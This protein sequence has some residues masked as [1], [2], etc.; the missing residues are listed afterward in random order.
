MAV[1]TVK[2]L[3]PWIA[4]VVVLIG[5]VNFFWF[6]AE[7]SSLGGDALSGYV[8]DGHWF[9]MSH[10]TST[11]VSQAD[12]EWS[13]LHASSVF[14]THP[15]AMAG[16]AYLLFRVFFPATLPSQRGP[17]ASERLE[18]VGASGPQVSGRRVAGRLGDL[19]L[20]GPLLDVAVH[21]G[22]VVL[23]PPFMTPVVLLADEILGLSW[24]RSWGSDRL[25]IQYRPGVWVGPMYLFVG[26]TDPIAV[27]I[28]SL[29]AKNGNSEGFASTSPT[30]APDPA[31]F[32]KFPLVMKVWIVGALAISV[33]LVFS[34]D[35]PGL[36]PAFLFGLAIVAGN[37]YWLVVRNRHRW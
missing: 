35:R 21:P 11:E 23:K 29:L 19:R 22:G 13:R 32:S 27:A 24:G 5:F 37:V 2:R 30:I 7:S 26:P 15:L 33:V 6:A 9:V 10:G 17:A 28:E 20:S 34:W 8:R 4:M 31:R 1:D 14:L 3:A 36:N 12:W 25:T 18:V 16:L